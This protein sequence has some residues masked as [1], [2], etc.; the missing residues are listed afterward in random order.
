M[1]VLKLGKHVESLEY[2]HNQT[3]LILKG[4][5]TVSQ[6]WWSSWKGT[7][8][9]YAVILTSKTELVRKWGFAWKIFK[10]LCWTA[11]NS[12]KFFFQFYISKSLKFSDKIY[13]KLKSLFFS[14]LMKNQFFNEKGYFPPKFLSSQNSNFHCKWA[15]K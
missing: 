8:I 11:K 6:G 4:P 15:L 14:C 2:G 10:T 9:L 12:K 7:R 5:L 1:K 13:W 3:S